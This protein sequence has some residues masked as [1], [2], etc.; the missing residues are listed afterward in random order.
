MILIKWKSDHVFLPLWFPFFLSRKSSQLLRAKLLFTVSPPTI[1][2][3]CQLLAAKC[4]LLSSL[5]DFMQTVLCTWYLSSS[6]LQVK[7]SCSLLGS[8]WLQGK[9]SIPERT[10]PYISPYNS[11]QQWSQMFFWYQGPVSRRTYFST[12]WGAW[13]GGVGGGRRRGM[14]E[15]VSGWFKYIKLIVHFIS[16]TITSAPPQII[17]H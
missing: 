4:H 6:F 3:F 15:M 11:L 8:Q 17:R 12:D 7:N 1:V 9:G 2:G 16:V 13:C 10:S 5:H 14:V